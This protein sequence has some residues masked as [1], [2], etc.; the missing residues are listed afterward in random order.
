MSTAHVN[1]VPQYDASGTS[2]IQ[3]TECNA[4]TIV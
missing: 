2:P 3:T 1:L 4:K